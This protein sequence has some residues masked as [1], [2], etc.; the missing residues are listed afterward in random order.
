MS[1]EVVPLP[2]KEASL[3]PILNLTATAMN[4]VNAI[5]LD[6][7]QSEIP[8]IPAA[9]KLQDEV[10]GAPSFQEADESLL[11][12]ERRAVEAFKKTSLM[13]FG[14]AMQTYGMKLSDEQEVL[15]LLADMLI[16]VFAAE[17]AVLRAQA[18]AAAS[19]AHADLH[20]DAARVFVN[21]AAMRMDA[22]ARQAL[23]AMSEGDTLRTMLAALRR[24]LKVMPV[25]TVALRRRIAGEAASRGGYIF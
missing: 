4:A 6:R 23:A 18:A 22:N 24:V 3:A 11:D 15:M 5:I 20:A 8:L 16:D 10:L 14:L 25:N 17:S 1:A 12:E 2:R 21:D 9:K 19:A 7:M 13:I